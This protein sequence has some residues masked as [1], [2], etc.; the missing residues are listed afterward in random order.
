MKTPTGD[1]WPASWRPAGQVRLD[2]ASSQGQAG[3]VGAAPGAG[4][5][6][7]PVQVGIDGADTDEQLGGDLR[8]ATALGDQGDQLAFPG[9][10]PGQLRRLLGLQAW[11]GEQQRV[12]GGGGWAHRRAAVLRCPGPCGPERLLGLVQRF[13]PAVR[14]HRW[15][16]ELTLPVQRRVGGPYRDG[17]SGAPGCGAQIPTPVQA[18]EQVNPVARARADLERFPQVLCGILEAACP[19]LQPRQLRQYPRQ[20][21]RVAR[22]PGLGQPR[23]AH[24][25]GGGQ[26]PGLDQPGGQPDAGYPGY[27]ARDDAG[28]DLPG[29]PGQPQELSEIVGVNSGDAEDVQG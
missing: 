26:V 13:P 8:V 5:V 23:R 19:Q 2:Q 22:V 24:A 7:D 10:Q 15:V 25:L 3:Q 20:A 11:G 4:L 21:P 29:L 1:Y 9:A 12:L 14:G 18:V 27:P 16:G 17:L 28:R 6:P